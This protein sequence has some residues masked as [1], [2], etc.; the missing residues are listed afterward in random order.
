MK[1]EPV[2]SSQVEAIG[3]DP[4]TQVMRVKF[5][6][7]GAEYDY[8]GVTPELHAATL[9]AESIGKFLGQHIKGKHAFKKV[10]A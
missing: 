6:N 2:T 4:A 8:A 7:A 9:K 10:S 3:Y 1:L 5:K